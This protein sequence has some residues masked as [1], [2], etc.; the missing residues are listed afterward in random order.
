MPGGT[1]LSCDR[2]VLYIISLGSEC[3]QN[4]SFQ[5]PVSL[6]SFRI[7][8]GTDFVYFAALLC[9]SAVFFF[10]AFFLFLP[11]IIIAP[12]KFALS[13]TCG[14]I[15]TMSA[16]LMLSGWK[17]GLAHMVSRERLPFTGIYLGSM[18]A[19]LY[20]AVSMHSYI[21]S[22]GF[23]VVQVRSSLLRACNVAPFNLAAR[24]A[25]VLPVP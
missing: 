21:L 20:A 24:S 12:G 2:A 7:P 8:S 14:S 17:A 3:W 25:R 23:S 22:I 6:C 15:C 5:T 18:A 10:L 4:M 11:M 19:T 1:C 16:M 9:G 13:F